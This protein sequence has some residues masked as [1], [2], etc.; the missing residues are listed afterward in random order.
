MRSLKGRVSAAGLA[1]A[2]LAMTQTGNAQTAKA[3]AAKAPAASVPAGANVV[4]SNPVATDDATITIFSKRPIINPG[5][6]QTRIDLGSQAS[7]CANII[8]S[9][10]Q[11]IVDDYFDSFYGTAS[12]AQNNNALNAV[13]DG[14]PDGSALPSDGDSAAALAAN[15]GRLRVNPRSP[16]GDASTDNDNL[17][18]SGFLSQAENGGFTAPGANIYGSSGTSCTVAERTFAASRAEI[19]ARDQSLY[20]AY[21]AFNAKDYPKAL[22]LFKYAYDKIGY[23]E[24]AMMV[25]KMYLFGLG[26]APDSAQ[27]AIW[28][29]K[30]AELPF[31]P[32]KYN[33]KRQRFN[34]ANPG[35]MTTRTES[36]IALARLYSF[37]VGL[38]K[39]PKEA[40][41]WYA[42]A[43][44]EGYIPA[45]HIMGLISQQ[46][47]GGEK[48]LTK[49]IGYFKKAGQ[50]GY[51]L[52]QYT[53]GELYYYGDEGV[54]VDKT[55]AGAWL[56]AA[57]K[58][59]YPDA[60]Y[61]VGRM[62][63]LGEG[64]ATVDTAKAL[65]YY[66]EAAVKGQPDAQY[67]IG[68]DFYLGNGVPK[69]LTA[70]RRW[71]LTASENGNPDAMF[72]LAVMMVN[73]EGGPKDLV[74]AYAWF[75][76]ADKGGVEKAGAA[77]RELA[78]KMTPDERA[79]AD[80]LLSPKAK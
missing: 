12:D 20:K 13:P 27:A 14:S 58:H 65:V 35:A 21:D 53:L 47:Y 50:A 18:E 6:R 37:G 30:V 22:E 56:L 40:R 25:A 16:H 72:N 61:A 45:T 3:P 17:T 69:D 4:T 77:M 55:L 75:Y 63:E 2:V 11:D 78:T 33:A 73:G 48:S 15:G 39:D 9:P 32:S 44:D 71:F 54:P 67:V 42:R 66:K 57:A 7:G 26:T 49:A 29:K 41:R 31:D 68:T 23:E 43:D 51:A 64:G 38:P 24:A 1:F 70:A 34:P 5:N 80:A 8:A 79:Q 19:A 10:G 36:I 46:G 59:G 76:I 60:L 74:K 62:Y 52:S 28:L